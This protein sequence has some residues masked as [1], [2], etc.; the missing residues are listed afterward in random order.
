MGQIRKIYL[1]WKAGARLRSEDIERLADTA[2]LDISRN[3][4]RE[5]GRD[6]DRSSEITPA[7]LYALISA[8][9]DEQRNPP[10]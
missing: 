1:A 10:R 7:E 6:S 2:G 9:T 8:W 5:L 3:R 4:L